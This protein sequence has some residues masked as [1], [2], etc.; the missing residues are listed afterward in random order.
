VIVL[1]SLNPRSNILPLNSI[2][3]VPDTTAI[4]PEGFT[5]FNCINGK[6]IKSTPTAPTNPN[7][8]T[9]S[10]THTH[11]GSGAHTHT[12]ACLGHTHTGTAGGTNPNGVTVPDAN[13]GASS[14]SHSHTYTSATGTPTITVGCSP[15]AH[16]HC[17]K[18]N[19]QAYRTVALFKK[20]ESSIPLRRRLLSENIML[21]NI[22]STINPKLTKDTGF[23]C[24]IPY[25]CTTTGCNVG[26]NCHTHSS[27]THQHCLNVA[28]HSH[29]MS[30]VGGGSGTIGVRSGPAPA[31]G[32][33]S[34]A[35][36]TH[37]AGGTLAAVNPCNVCST[38]SSTHTHGNQ[39]HVIA[40]KTVNF[41]YVNLLKLR[42]SGVPPCVM[43]NWVCNVACIPTGFQVADGTNCTFNMLDKYP[44]SSCTP[45]CTGGSNTHTHASDDGCHT[46]GNTT[47]PHT[48]TGS[49]NT[50]TSPESGI[51]QQCANP[52]TA[53]GTGHSHPIGSSTSNTLSVA[54]TGTAGSH[55]HDA[56][57][58][59][60]PGKTLAFVQ[61]I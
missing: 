16:N 34:P 61:K 3:I 9:G 47:V 13:S 31:S 46:H 48:H 18:T 60:P 20:T 12:G 42:E 33:K 1:P 30:S 45:G 38:A 28:S 51:W 50:A 43:F 5:A 25:A 52:A 17:A 35:A 54:L 40:Y 8:C 26:T 57:N 59:E 6:F 39:S 56:Q 10:S 53:S 29:T 36:H 7:V 24:K 4:T 2:I 22:K 23:N 14:P 32:P 19:D 37:A 55:T 21:Y 15:G 58:H 44:R 49:G 27:C 11:S 41:A